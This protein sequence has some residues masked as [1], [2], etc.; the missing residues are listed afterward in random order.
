MHITCMH[1]A[2]A[3]M[4]SA[5]NIVSCF[6]RMSHRLVK[7]ALSGSPERATVHAMRKVPCM[8]AQVPGIGEILAVSSGPDG[9]SVATGGPV[10]G[11]CIEY[12]LR[13]GKVSYVIHPHR[14]ILLEVGGQVS[15]K[16]SG[17]QLLL[18]A[19]G[20]AK[21]IR[22]DVLSMTLRSEQE[23]RE[24]EKEWERENQ[25]SRHYPSGC[26][27]ESGMEFSCGEDEAYR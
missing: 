6:Y 2:M 1:M 19:S 17:K 7:P 25:P 21:E 3:V 4:R 22:C 13:T 18:Q 27:T 20:A 16:L 15:I 11:E 5:F 9:G 12:E 10:A 24:Q 23:K 8:E 14:A 26:Y